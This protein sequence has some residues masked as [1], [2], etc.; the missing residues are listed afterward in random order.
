MLNE[1]GIL[2]SRLPFSDALFLPELRQ[3]HVHVPDTKNVPLLGL[4]MYKK[5]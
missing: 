2:I 3:W 4:Q 5:Q 1:M